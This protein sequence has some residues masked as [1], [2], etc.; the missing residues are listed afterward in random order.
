MLKNSARNS[1]FTF[2]VIGFRLITETSHCWV[3]GPINI[4]RPAFPKRGVPL[5]KACA[6]A[7]VE[8]QLTLNHSATVWGPAPLHMRSGLGAYASVLEKSSFARTEKGKPL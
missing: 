7:V 1:R 6:S 4:L 3:P 2:S 5:A 8:K